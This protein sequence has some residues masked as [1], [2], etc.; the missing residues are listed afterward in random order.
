MSNVIEKNS[1]ELERYAQLK[2][3]EKAIQAEIDELAPKIVEL[4][5]AN[6]LD[7]IDSS[8]GIFSLMNRKNWKFSP[9]VDEAKK[10][11]EAMQE[12]EKATGVATF[13]EKSFLQF[14]EQKKDE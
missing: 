1:A 3:S 9:A 6:D 11:L 2:I 13:Q 5:K 8:F 12:N 4:L 14:K 7:K 10:E